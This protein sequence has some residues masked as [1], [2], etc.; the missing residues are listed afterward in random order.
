MLP[1][2][3]VNISGNTIIGNGNTIYPFAAIGND[4]QDLKFDGEKNKLVIGDN[5]KIRD[6]GERNQTYALI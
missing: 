2:K 5:N 1:R 4:P 3:E 6:G